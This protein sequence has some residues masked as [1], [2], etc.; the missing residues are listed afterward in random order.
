MLGFSS[1]WLTHLRRFAQR[2]DWHV[3]IPALVSAYMVFYLIWRALETINPQVPVLSWLLWG[4]EAFS[5]VNYLLFSWMTRRIDPPVPYRPP[6]P[7]LSVDV[8]IPTYNEDI[9]IL[10]AT[11]T[12]CRLMTY[13]HRTYLL[14][15]GRREEVRKLAERFGVGYITRPDNR[16]AK[17]GNLNHALKQTNGE[18]IVVLDADMVPQPNFLERTLGYF[19]DERLAFV[20]LPQEFY[21]LDSVQHD[22]S[23]PT[24]HEQSLFFHVIQP[25]KNYSNS[26]FW[27]GS[28]S[29]I[30]RKALEEVGGVATE[31]ITED[32][33]TS[34]R[35]HSRGWKSLFV[36]ESLA[37][38]IAP[39]TITAYLLQRLRW[40][41]G[42]MQLY[43]SKESPLWIRGLTLSQRLSYLASFLAYIESVQKFIFLMMPVAILLLNV[44]PMRVELPR[45]L[46]F[47]TPYFILNI[48]ANQFGGRGYFRYFKSEIYAFLRMVVFIQSLLVLVINKPLKFQVTPKSVDRSVYE[49]ERSAL[50]LHFALL[51]AMIGALLFGSFRLLVWGAAG[52][53]REAFWIVLF[54]GLY[55]ASVIYMGVREVLSRRHE[56]RHYRFP[57]NLSGYLATGEQTCPVQ[58]QNLSLS[59]AGLRAPVSL[60]ANTR[61]TGG[62]LTFSTPYH[63][64]IRVP[65]K[66]VVF[67][68]ADAK[69][70]LEGGAAFD[71]LELAERDRLLEYLF[72]YRPGEIF[73]NTLLQSA[74]QAVSGVPLQNMATSSQEAP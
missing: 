41:Q 62:W 45:F 16:H 54:W 33:H 26:A 24:W 61:L 30:R 65:L 46:I 60:Q 48:L 72:V 17:A 71:E 23:K 20:Q 11:L 49:K 53:S 36:N 52:L 8:F 1:A 25:G 22:Q 5:V 4:A 27:C 34:V 13:P 59:G 37:F 47:W 66:S 40:A 74:P 39:Q 12:G 21:N 15:D 67:R 51:G 57:V 58:I 50:R 10:E 19:E 6:R 31:T 14:D 70:W 64:R 44:L 56:R 55:N 68:R 35:L 42:T 29:V 32:I 43:R 73:A 38:G 7:G 3:W 69:G 9:E 18:F 63:P 2:I 28:P